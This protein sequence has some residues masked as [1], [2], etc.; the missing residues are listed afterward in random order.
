MKSASL[1]FSVLLAWTDCVYV[2]EPL[3]SPVVT[4]EGWTGPLTAVSEGAWDS[5]LPRS[6]IE[7]GA[8]NQRRTQYYFPR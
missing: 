6:A 3:S 4:N 7:A 5:N 2:A 8:G 1:N